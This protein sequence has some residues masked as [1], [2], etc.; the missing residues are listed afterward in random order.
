M[1]RELAGAE[2][3]E[4]VGAPAPNEIAARAVGDSRDRVVVDRTRGRAAKDEVVARA[5]VDVGVA[6]VV[7]RRAQSATVDVEA[8]RVVVLVRDRVEVGRGG[9]LPRRGGITNSP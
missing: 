5:V 9:E 6:V 8:A 1:R 3:R 7:V 2:S 4:R